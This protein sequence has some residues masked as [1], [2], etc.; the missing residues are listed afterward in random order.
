[1]T[2]FE[3]KSWYVTLGDTFFFSLMA[4]RTT[5][6]VLRHFFVQNFRYFWK[7]NMQNIILHQVTFNPHEVR[8]KFEKLGRLTKR[9]L[10]IYYFYIL[11]SISGEKIID[12]DL[13]L[14][15][16]YVR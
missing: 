9:I 8:L 12:I 15:L 13:D 16:A 11:G 2:N 4:H 3:L 14:Y 1:M 7:C 5:L 10:K 6:L